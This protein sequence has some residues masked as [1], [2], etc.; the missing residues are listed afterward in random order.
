MLK[1]FCNGICLASAWIPIQIVTEKRA[2]NNMVA[3][4]KVGDV[5]PDEYPRKSQI[6]QPRHY[7]GRG[8]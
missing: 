7:D 8:Q 4:A 1:L 6:G 2:R 5:E 3:M